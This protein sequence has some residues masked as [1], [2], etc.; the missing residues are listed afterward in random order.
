[1]SRNVSLVVIGAIVLVAGV[2]FYEVMINYFVP[3][4]IAIVMTLIFQPVHAWVRKQC[5]GRD[6]LAAGLTT[7]AILVIVLG[8]LVGVVLRAALDIQA[9]VKNSGEVQFNTK[10]VEDL[11]TDVNTRFG[12]NLSADDIIKRIVTI[13]TNIATN[14]PA[15][16]GSFLFG[17]LVMIFS[18]FYFL[19]DGPEMI[20]AV[21]KLLP[22]KSG[23]QSQLLDEFESVS[24]AIVSAT[25]LSA[26]AQ[27][28]LAAF[29]FW[30]FGVNSVFLLMLLTMVLSMVP[31][32]GSMSVWGSAAAWLYFTG[33]PTSAIFLVIYG[34]GIISMADNIVKPIVLGGHSNLHPLWALLSVL[35]GLQAMGPIGVFVGPLV[36]AFLQAALKMLQQEL[37]LLDKRDKVKESAA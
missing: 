15:F 12:L 33:H 21:S 2:L 35:G 25:L 22:L 27:G 13:L 11:V 23:Y 32:V 7:A 5:R 29:G 9:Y 31:F 36:F 17:F 28:L 37:T 1:M 8:P 34:F 16:L 24:R 10:W 30:L 18:L 4:F 26:L 19:A 3:V 6:R 20:K 14:L